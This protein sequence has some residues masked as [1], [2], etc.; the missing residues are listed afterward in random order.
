MGR[1]RSKAIDSM[2]HEWREAPWFVLLVIVVVAFV[3]PGLL[4]AAWTTLS[5]QF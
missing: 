5:N 4:W 2:R 1:R 3:G